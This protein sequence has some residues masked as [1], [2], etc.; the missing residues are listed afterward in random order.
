[1]IDPGIGYND[2]RGPDD[3]TQDWASGRTHAGL[4]GSTSGIN[5][6]GTE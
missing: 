6:V 1:M 2:R 5:G 3:R 4:L